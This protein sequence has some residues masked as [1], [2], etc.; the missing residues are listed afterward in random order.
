LLTALK[1]RVAASSLGMTVVSTAMRDEAYRLGL[2]PP[3]LRV[4]PMGVDLH[5]RFTVDPTV[6]RDTDHLLFVGRLVPKKGLRYLLDAMPRVISRRPGVVL[7]IVGFGPEE[8]ALRMQAKALGIAKHV[9]FLGAMPQDALPALY[10]RASLFVA[11]FIRDASGNQEG[12]P[13]V[14]M[15]A[16]GCGCPVLV[17]DVAGVADLLGEHHRQASVKADDADALASA[18]IDILDQPALAAERTAEIR[19]AA[20]DSINWDVIAG[21]YGDLLES[22]LPPAGS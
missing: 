2:R 16:I 11:P 3:R 4:L 21:R 14:L 9:R 6:R 19:A 18:I 15:E 22:V 1:R 20:V 8:D 5:D 17:G 12:L 10:R 7:E 13:V